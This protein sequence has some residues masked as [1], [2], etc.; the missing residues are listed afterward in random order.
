MKKDCIW[1]CQTGKNVFRVVKVSDF[2]LDYGNGYRVYLGRKWWNH[3]TYE[4]YEDAVR[5]AIYVSLLGIFE[6]SI[7]KKS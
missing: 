5:A 6:V 4:R 7:I 2:M 1:K 3:Y